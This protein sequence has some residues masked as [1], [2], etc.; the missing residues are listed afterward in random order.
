MQLSISKYKVCAT[1]MRW[2]RH[3][4]FRV[5]PNARANRMYLVPHRSN[6]LDAKAFGS[7][8][9]WVKSFVRMSTWSIHR[10]RMCFNSIE[11]RAIQYMGTV[12]RKHKGSP[13]A[14]CSNLVV[15]WLLM[16]FCVPQ[17]M[18]NE[19]DNTERWMYKGAHTRSLVIN[20]NRNKKFIRLSTNYLWADP[21]ARL[22]HSQRLGRRVCLFDPCVYGAMACLFEL[23]IC[24]FPW[25]SACC[26]RRSIRLLEN[27]Q[28]F[29]NKKL[30]QARDWVLPLDLNTLDRNTY[31]K[32]L[33][34]LATHT[35]TQIPK[36]LISYI[37]YFWPKRVSV[38]MHSFQ[39]QPTIQQ[40]TRN[41]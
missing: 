9:R 2:R 12:V 11:C 33:Y 4:M 28:W 22:I 26:S 14:T 5:T 34:I 21:S 25:F 30:M 19:K 18:H 3:K 29:M 6:G 40:A 41:R 32:V 10:A 31:R 36:M 16:P 17:N 39:M 8:W 37:S 38:S 15:L 13:M 35:N 7:L 1:P 24:H 23:N 27:F 20:W